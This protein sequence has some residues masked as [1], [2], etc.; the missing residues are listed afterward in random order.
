MTNDEWHALVSK[1]TDRMNE[2]VKHSVTP[3]SKYDHNIPKFVGTGTFLLKDEKLQ[4]VSAAHVISDC[5]E[6]FCPFDKDEFLALEEAGVWPDPNVDVGYFPLRD[7]KSLYGVHALHEGVIGS[8][9]SLLAGEVLYFRGCSGENTMGMP[10]QLSTLPSGYCVQQ[11]AGTEEDENLQVLW[12]PKEFRFSEET[13]EV[14]RNRLKMK[15]PKGLS[16]S[17]LWDTGFVRAGCD[18]STWSPSMAKV[19]GIIVRW[20]KDV[21]I[22]VPLEKTYLA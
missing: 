8:S 12:K 4:I 2:A 20:D 22:A 21:L 6:S 14:A 9:Q 5:A 10:G 3:L 19:V 13:E 11:K 16:G 7:S 17:L 18:H 1:V 15:N